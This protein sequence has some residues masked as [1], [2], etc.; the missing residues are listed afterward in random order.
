MDLTNWAGLTLTGIPAEQILSA[1]QACDPTTAGSI[2]E[3]LSASWAC[4]HLIR[5]LTARQA[6]YLAESVDRYDALDQPDRAAGARPLEGTDRA[7]AEINPR[8]ALTKG[9]AAWRIR[10]A[11]QLR[12]DL[13]A[14]LSLVDQG[15][16]EYRSAGLVDRLMRAALE[17]D[18]PA[19]NQVARHITQ[20]APGLTSCQLEYAVRHAIEVIDPIAAQNRHKRAYK[21][22]NVVAYPLGDGMGAITATLSADDIQLTDEVLDR[23]ADHCRDHN[24]ANGTPDPRSRQQLR[25]DAHAALFRSIADGTPLPMIFDP[26]PTPTPSPIPT[27][28]P[29]N[30]PATSPEP[31]TS[32]GS[33]HDPA[34]RESA[35]APQPT[36]GTLP[37]GSASE[38]GQAPIPSAVSS[39]R[40]SPEQR[41]DEELIQRSSDPDHVLF[42][43]THLPVDQLPLDQ[44]PLDLLPLDL[45]PPDASPTALGVS[46]REQFS[47]CPGVIAWWMPPAL[48]T[49]HGRTTHLI[50]TM[51]AT[52]LS[53]QDE[54]PADLSGHGPI[55]ANLARKIAGQAG[56]TS[57]IRLPEGDRPSEFSTHP[58]A[59]N[60]HPRQSDKHLNAGDNHSNA[61]SNRW[62][63]GDDRSNRG[64]HRSNAGSNRWNAGDD[65][66]KRGN[67]RS[68]AGDNNPAG[69]NVRLSPGNDRSTAGNDQPTAGNDRPTAANDQPTAGND[70]PDTGNTRNT[71][72]DNEIS[73]PATANPLLDPDAQ[74][75]SSGREAG[76]GGEFGDGPRSKQPQPPRPQVQL[77]PEP[78]QVTRASR[79]PL[80]SRA[81]QPSPSRSQQAWSFGG[82]NEHGPGDVGPCPNAARPYKPS[83]SLSDE[84]T[85]LHPRC[86][87]PGC[88]AL[89]ERC[90][91]DHVR[92]YRKG[93]PSCSCNMQ[94]LCRTH[95]RLK[96]F[97]GWRARFTT[98]DEPHQAGTVEWTTELGLKQV[99]PPAIR[100]GSNGWQPAGLSHAA[101]TQPDPDEPNPPDWTTPEARNTERHRQWKRQLDRIER[102]KAPARSSSERRSRKPGAH[103]E[104]HLE[105]LP[106]VEPGT[107]A[108]T[109]TDT[110]TDNE[111]SSRSPFF[112]RALTRSLG[113]RRPLVDRSAEPPF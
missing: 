36:I 15:R 94:P 32:H 89:A 28:S 8:F 76:A 45:L 85:G 54:L 27:P 59:D 9:Q 31:A 18:S 16:V 5:T 23:L 105:D 53:G 52:T 75:D 44:L 74:L 7:G 83:R 84:I 93:G 3:L 61:G 50:L 77:P 91:L 87:Y 82:P 65:R 20:I 86:T 12:T 30:S 37:A 2:P 111:P 39:S 6:H 56:R 43:G 21:D 78:Q 80:S 35:W 98:S 19:W 90:D 72:D 79:T 110:D 49:R 41:L 68:N 106:D 88:T 10:Q 40:F 4:E 22:R 103:K 67:N 1:V 17:P 63:A 46:D 107:T 69:S 55:P 38:I 60:D 13:P 47:R 104:T 113:N 26:S 71:L 29:A 25:A 48:P 73:A 51:A 70:Q 112:S 14:L 109:G 108:T 42:G 66:S 81:P 33:N 102:K 96:T 97:G 62:N 11:H 64:N 58:N 34:G 24:K 92:P 99:T 100:P 95:H 101:R 57:F